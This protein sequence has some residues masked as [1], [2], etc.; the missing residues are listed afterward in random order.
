MSNE[1]LLFVSYYFSCIG[2]PRERSCGLGLHA[3]VAL[4]H[5]LAKAEMD[6]WCCMHFYLIRHMI[7]NCAFDQADNGARPELLAFVE[8]FWESLNPDTRTRLL[9]I[10]LNEVRDRAKHLG[11]LMNKSGVWDKVQL[12][13]GQV[14]T[15]KH[16][17]CTGRS[18]KCQFVVQRYLKQQYAVW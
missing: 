11:L 13:Y 2:S 4:Q 5:S 18:L 10:G 12:G 16:R 14:R 8:P 17:S 7:S 15:V 9:T 6:L 3:K 1:T